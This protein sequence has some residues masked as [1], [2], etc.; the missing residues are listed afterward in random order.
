MNTLPVIITNVLTLLWQIVAG[1]T[2][3]MIIFAGFLFL[4]SVGDP[5]KITK[6]KAA[7]L[8]AVVGLVVCILAY[9]IPSIIS[10]ALLK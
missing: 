7:V 10:N 5:S 8:W 6:A 1:L 2:V 9:S 4:T 3:V